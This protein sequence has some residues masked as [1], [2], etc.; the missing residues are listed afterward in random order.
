MKDKEYIEH[1]QKRIK[2]TNRYLYRYYKDLKNI[3]VRLF[4]L[5]ENTQLIH[6]IKKLLNERI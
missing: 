5:K 1:L 4:N 6:D 2:R 3:D